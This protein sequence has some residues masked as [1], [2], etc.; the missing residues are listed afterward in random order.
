M[1]TPQLR[2][3]KIFSD[4]VVLQSGQENPIWGRAGAGDEVAVS[5][6]GHTGST[7]ADAAGKW[8]FRLAATAPGGPHTIE[9]SSRSEKLT[10]RDVLVGEV[11]LC[12]GQSNMEW[13]VAMSNDAEREIA[14][15]Q[16]PSIRLLKI[17]H[18]AL[19]EP[20]DEVDAAWQ[21]CSPETVRDFSAVAYY[22]GRDLHQTRNVPI[23][24]VDSSWGGSNAETWV[25]WSDLKGEPA[26]ENFMAPYLESFHETPEGRARKKEIL[27]QWAKVERWKD[28]GNRG[29]FFDWAEPA[30]DDSGWSTY[31]VPGFWQNQGMPFNGSV[32]F[33]K[34]I[35]VPLEWAGR[36][37]LVSLGRLD[38]YDDAYFNGVHVG[39]TG[40]ETP[41]WWLTSRCYKIPAKLVVPGKANTIAVRIFDDY[42]NGGFGGGAPS[43][44]YPA[45]AQPE[46][47]VSLEGEWKCRVE[48]ALEATIPPRVQKLAVDSGPNAFNSPSNLYNAMIAPLAPYGFKGVIWYQGESN[49][50]RGQQYKILFPR[51][52]QSWRKNFQNPHLGFFFVLLAN[53]GG[54]QTQPVESSWT[55]IREAQLEALELPL[56]GCASA[57]DIGDA[58]DIHPTDKQSVGHRLALSARAIL[59][60]EK[61]EHDGPV[62]AQAKA[63]GPVLRLHFKNGRGLKTRD[64]GPLVGFAARAASGQWVWAEAKIDDEDVVLTHP[65]KV[66]I[67][68][69][70]YAW[71]SNPIG[72]LANAAGLP[73]APFRTDK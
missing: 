14:A 22:F 9:I 1:T 70:R 8:S 46:A 44:V 17:P 47:G 29:Y 54:R 41:N 18:L 27:E 31:H 28:P 12:S 59:Y 69:V 48:L 32:W 6:Q 33:R 21:I 5:W 45:D 4:H 62:F 42:G 63:D 60:G 24:L 56:T 53:Y 10:V 19:A 65:A 52:I 13:T 7:R 51:L 67:A 11:W 66:P 38:D 72:N 16:Y 36:D 43:A 58:D 35:E 3:P 55:E 37:L 39:S 64:G 50:D 68:H 2:L 25:E 30:F 73:A 26:F 15:A 61:L 40:S 20:S 23:G 57:I 49:G 34:Q 71:A